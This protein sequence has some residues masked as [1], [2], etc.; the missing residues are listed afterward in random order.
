MEERHGSLA[1]AKREMDAASAAW[2]ECSSQLRK[3]WDRVETAI[4]EYNKCLSKRDKGTTE[5]GDYHV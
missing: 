1:K 4:D 3:A 2:A 5:K